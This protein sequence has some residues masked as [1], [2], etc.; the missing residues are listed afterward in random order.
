MNVA[1]MSNLP[2]G[3]GRVCE[4][5]TTHWQRDIYAQCH[6]CG[7]HIHPCPAGMQV[8]EEHQ[9]TGLH[10]RHQGRRL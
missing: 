7:G 5:S 10:V 2:M 6:Q 8:P 4:C 3:L 9:P 1:A